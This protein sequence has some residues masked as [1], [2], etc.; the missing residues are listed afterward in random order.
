MEERDAVRDLCRAVNRR[1]Y[2]VSVVSAAML[3]GW[4]IGS[5]WWCFLNYEA[6]GEGQKIKNTGMVGT[7]LRVQI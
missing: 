7:I 5:C 2:R 4:F 6:R 3:L 1:L